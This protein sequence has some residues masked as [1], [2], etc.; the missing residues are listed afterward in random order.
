MPNQDVFG[1]TGPGTPEGR[2]AG[3]AEPPKGAAPPALIIGVEVVVTL[4]EQL[5]AIVVPSSD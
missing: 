2:L 5:E 4:P 3:R 1:V